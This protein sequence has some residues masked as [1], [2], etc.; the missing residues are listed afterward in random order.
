M[1]LLRSLTHRDHVAEGVSFSAVAK[2]PGAAQVFG[3]KQRRGLTQVACEPIKCFHQFFNLP[4]VQFPA[5]LSQRGRV[6]QKAGRRYA[7]CVRDIG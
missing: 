5:F 1:L 4:F 3:H 6:R 2:L 7:R